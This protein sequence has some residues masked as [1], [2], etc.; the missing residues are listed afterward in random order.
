MDNLRIVVANE[1]RA[2][3]DAIAGAVARLRPDTE[4]IDVAPEHLD[5]AI[6]RHRPGLVICSWLTGAMEDHAPAWIL[7]Y[8]DFVNEATIC[9]AGEPTTIPNVDFATLL[10]VV[11]RVAAMAET[12]VPC[13]R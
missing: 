13:L 8:P 6:T 1:P 3:R 2:Y 9:V 11:D 5:A 7:L 4:V 12:D 10:A